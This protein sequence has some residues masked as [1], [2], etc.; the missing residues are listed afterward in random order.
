[1]VAH[2]EQISG[3]TYGRSGFFFHGP[4]QNVM[5]Y[6]QESEG[7]VVAPHAGRMAIKAIAPEGSIIEVV[8]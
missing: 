4:A 5:A 7:C 1:M 2:L 6:G 8:E 3:E